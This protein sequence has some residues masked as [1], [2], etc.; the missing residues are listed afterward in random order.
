MEFLETITSF[1]NDALIP[2]DRI[3][4]INLSIISEN[5]IVIKIISDDGHW[6]EHF[7]DED[8][9]DTRYREIKKIVEGE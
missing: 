9:A 8:D 6:E 7:D 1:G 2:I 3:K 4:Y 5:S